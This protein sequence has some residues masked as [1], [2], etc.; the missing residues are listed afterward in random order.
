MDFHEIASI[1][2]LME[3]E[4]YRA[5]V[6]D[7]RANGLREPI[8]TYEGKIIDGRNRYRAC[9]EL[10]ITPSA[11]EWDGKGSLIGF[12]VSLNLHRRHLTS[13]Q[14][15]V[16]ASDIEPMLAEEARKRMLTGRA[17]DPVEKFPQ[18]R[19]GEQAAKLAG[20]NPHYVADAKRLKETAPELVQEVK[21]GTVTIPEANQLASL[22]REQRETALEKVKTGEAKNVRAAIVQTNK[23]EAAKLGAR[24]VPLPV[25]KFRVIEADP[26]WKMDGE[27]GKS[28][29]LQYPLMDLESIKAL[30]PEII[31]M[32]DDNCHLYLWAINPMLRE[33]FEVMEAWGFTYKTCLT[34]IKSNGFG[35]GHYFRGATE[36]VLFGVRGRL[37]TLQKDQRNY[38]EAPRR[39]HS[40]KPDEFYEVAE[41]MSP[42]PR[43]R[44][45][46]RSARAGWASWGNEL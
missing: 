6:D 27:E 21:A 44:L 15:A 29:V 18:G 35:T 20:T 14:K 3:G 34:W 2:P 42:G 39:E 17:P 16:I 45:F 33:A 31:K 4:E 43:V 7:I 28:Q 13:S 1:F 25:G 40:S 32:A 8:W 46:A 36:H 30:R 10:G 26:P 37:D 9:E 19:A 24:P 22:P 23:D 12:V 41:R 11:R 38:F 5:L